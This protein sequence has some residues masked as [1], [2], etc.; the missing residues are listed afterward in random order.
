MRTQFACEK[1]FSPTCAS[2]S[3]ISVSGRLGE[4][5]R[6]QSHATSGDISIGAITD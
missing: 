2:F 6:W 5:R 4:V 3:R 1:F